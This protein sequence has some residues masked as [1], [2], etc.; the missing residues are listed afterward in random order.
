MV[1]S[2]DAL[3]A[4][5]LQNPINVNEKSETKDYLAWTGTMP[6]GSAAVGAD[7]CADWNGQGNE[8]MAFY[9][10]NKEISSEWTIAKAFVGQPSQCGSEIGLYCFEQE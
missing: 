2:W 9:G 4:G 6:D 7:H 1:E 10:R 3:L 5:Q 8:N